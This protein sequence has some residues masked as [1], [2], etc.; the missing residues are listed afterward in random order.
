MQSE[1]K[2]K[3]VRLIALPAAVRVRC[4]TLVLALAL[5]LAAAAATGPALA[6]SKSEEAYRKKAAA[7]RDDDVKG[8][9]R[10]GLWCE[11]KGWKARARL[12]LEKVIALDPDHAGA[13]RKLGY[14]K[15]R[16]RWMTV[17]EK[18]EAEYRERLAKL[19]DDD[20]KGHLTLGT[21]CRRK[22]LLAC[23]VERFEKVLERDPANARAKRALAEAKRALLEERVSAYVEAGESERTDLLASIRSTD[24]IEEKEAPRWIEFVR[25]RLKRLPRHDGR[26]VSVTHH[27]K[28]S[29]KYRLLGRTRGKGLSLLIFLHGGGPS[30]SVNDQ[31]W[32]GFKRLTDTPF[33][34]VAIPRV[35]DDSTGAGWVM[36]SGPLAVR[37]VLAEVKRAYD[38]DPNRVY[39]AGSSMG[40]Y[41]TCWIGCLEPDRFAAL[42]IV[43]A[44]Y[45]GGGARLDNLLHTPI[46]CH[47]GENDHGS[48]HIGTARTLRK[49]LDLLR[50]WQPSGY[51]C[52]YKEYPGQGHSL[53]SGAYREVFDWMKGFERDPVPRKI[54]WT[55]FTHQRYVTHK[56]YYYWLKLERPRSGMR[57]EA[58]IKSGNEI[59]VKTREAHSFT[60]FLNG[61]LFDPTKPV[62][63]VVNDKTVH[64]GPLRPSLTAILESL[65]A[66]EDPY[67]VFS[68]RIDVGE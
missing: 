6:Q 17:R 52:L 43:A 22:G 18:D 61:R 29:V 13:R 28:F 34:L 45:G 16:G 14:I 50:R 65:V 48:D 49:R 30:S 10:L 59:V 62:K 19:A 67:Q 21:W 46:T 3:R 60:V 35:W 37:S 27:P 36:E 25:D 55:P 1:V 53:G 33:D 51:R 64:D 8:H 40:G 24:S 41:G 54:I 26:E 39:L 9:Y 58:E 66:K 42:G 44:G 68:Y 31:S 63:L 11:R 47:I 4:S 56:H 12:H 5:A 15:V 7:L 20:V 57:L 32:E 2:P 23:A 38:I